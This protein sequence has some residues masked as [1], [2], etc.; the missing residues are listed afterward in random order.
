MII[1]GLGYAVVTMPMSRWSYPTMVYF[2][3]TLHAQAAVRNLCL[4]RPLRAP[5]ARD[6]L[7]LCTS[8][9]TTTTER[10]CDEINSGSQDLYLCVEHPTSAHISLARQVN[11]LISFQRGQ[12]RLSYLLK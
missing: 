3:L 2:L 6:F 11:G 1:P 12:E 4:S 8:M 5:T 10:E 7:S 9:V